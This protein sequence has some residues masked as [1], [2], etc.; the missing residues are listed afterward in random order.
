MSEEIR[1]ATSGRKSAAVVGGITTLEAEYKRVLH[2]SRYE[3]KVYNRVKGRLGARIQS[4]DVIILFT[5]TVSHK[6][7]YEIRK[8]AKMRGIT[9][10]TVR[11]S[12][13]SALRKAMSA[14]RT[15][16]DAGR[17]SDA[18]QRSCVEDHWVISGR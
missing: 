17:D 1:G 18:G 8:A 12:S 3:A 9:L 7:A 10:R 5:A 16:S 4:A 2:E 11:P 6:M 15:P 13:V 14:M